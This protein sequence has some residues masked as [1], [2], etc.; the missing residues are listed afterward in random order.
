MDTDREERIRRR[1]HEI[2]EREGQPHG[3]DREHW[4]EA[5]REIEGESAGED[6]SFQRGGIDEAA[7]MSTAPGGLGTG[8]QPGGMKPGGGPDAAF[9][10]I[11][12]GGGSTAGKA[13]GDRKRTK[14]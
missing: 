13:T 4:S 12:T 10:S 7:A 9:G 11:G 1:A 5:A 14:R 6:R 3:R 2:W 8:L